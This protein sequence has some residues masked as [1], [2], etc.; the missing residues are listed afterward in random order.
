MC[1]Q[2][3]TRGRHALARHGCGPRRRPRSHRPEVRQIAYQVALLA[4]AGV[5]GLLGR[6]QRG[7]EPAP[8]E[9]RVGVR[10]PRPHLRLRHLPVADRVLQ[11][12][13][14]RPG[15]LGGPSQYAAGGR[16]RHRRRDGDRLH[17]RHRAALL[18]LA[19]RHAWPTVY[20]EILRNIPLLLQ[21]FFWYFAVLKG[22]PSPRQSSRCP[23]ASSST[24]AAS[25]VPAP[26]LAARLRRRWPV[27]FAVGILLAF[28]HPLVGPAAAD[29]DRPALPRCSG[30][31]SLAILGPAARRLPRRR[32]SARRSTFR[33]CAASTSRAASPCSRS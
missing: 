7:G 16:A 6:Q 15:V 18:Q 28:A 26:V 23:A 17:R 24:C 2:F 22:L 25:V 21:L 14:L 12:L 8:P 29:A 10:L 1:D 4:L 32:R 5:R 27:R 33:S 11:R 19:D 3:P 31:R 13:H 9:H 20:V 30:R